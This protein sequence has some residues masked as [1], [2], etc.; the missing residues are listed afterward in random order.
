MYYMYFNLKQKRKSPIIFFHSYINSIIINYYLIISNL[1]TVNIYLVMSNARIFIIVITLVKSVA[2]SFE[3]RRQIIS[4]SYIDSR[5]SIFR[6]GIFRKETLVTHRTG[7]ITAR[8]VAVG[9]SVRNRKPGSPAAARRNEI[10]GSYAAKTPRSAVGHKSASRSPQPPHDL[11]L[12]SSFILSFILHKIVETY[13][14][15][16]RNDR[17]SARTR[18]V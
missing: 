17:S 15:V 18:G 1:S 3:N 6:Y 8:R 4:R 5:V 16:R 11:S 2:I 9:D 7:A 13:P 10:G 12:L 14:L